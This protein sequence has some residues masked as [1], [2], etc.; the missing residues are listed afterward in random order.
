L[1]PE[2][3]VT[4]G[5]GVLVGKELRE[6]LGDGVRLGEADGVGVAAETVKLIASRDVV[7]NVNSPKRIAQIGTLIVAFHREQID[8]FIESPRFFYPLID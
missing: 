6:G 8:A 1:V 2:K 7:P 3:D 5:T 4:L